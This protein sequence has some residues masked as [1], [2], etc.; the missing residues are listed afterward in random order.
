M[1]SETDSPGRVD[2]T[3]TTTPEP[4]ILLLLGSGLVGLASLGAWGPGIA[5]RVQRPK[6]KMPA[7]AKSVQKDRLPEHRPHVESV[8]RL[9]FA[10]RQTTLCQPL[11]VVPLTRESHLCVAR[12]SAAVLRWLP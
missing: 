1:T 6:R 11:K 2:V 3:A 8:E 7:P 9:G 10:D 5:A 4:G 12:T